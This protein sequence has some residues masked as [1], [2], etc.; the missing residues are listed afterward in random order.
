MEVKPAVEQLPSPDARV[1]SSVL[2]V[3]SSDSDLIILGLRP[4]NLCL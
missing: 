4:R 1:D 2:K 3:H